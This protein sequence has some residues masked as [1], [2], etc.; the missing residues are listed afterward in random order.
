MLSFVVVPSD[1]LLLDNSAT[2]NNIFTLNTNANASVA[3]ILFVF[4]F[5][6]I[7]FLIYCCA[8]IH[9]DVPLIAKN[10]IIPSHFRYRMFTHTKEGRMN[11]LLRNRNGKNIFERVYGLMRVYTDNLH[12]CSSFCNRNIGTNIHHCDR[13]LLFLFH[14]LCIASLSLFVILSFEHSILALDSFSSNEFVWMFVLCFI[15]LFIIESFI[16]CIGRSTPNRLQTETIELLLC[17][18]SF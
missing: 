12:I 13:V 14:S 4:L 3:A 8:P 2:V 10:V 5:W 17:T 6:L 11:E 15:T 9:D 18:S 16:H 7:S 1:Y